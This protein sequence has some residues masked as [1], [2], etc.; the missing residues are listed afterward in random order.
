MV[1]CN[2]HPTVAA[3]HTASE[4]R[5]FL[6]KIYPEFLSFNLCGFIL[7]ASILSPLLKK[8]KVGS[9]LQHRLLEKPLSSK[10]NSREFSLGDSGS[11]IC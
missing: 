5:P 10:L 2:F 1:R 9:N 6:L 7:H 3:R 4:S 11:F 8:T